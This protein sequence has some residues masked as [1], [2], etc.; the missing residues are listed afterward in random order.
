MS[1]RTK[2][3]NNQQ[4]FACLMVIAGFHDFSSSKIDKHTVPD[5]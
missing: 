1:I 4:F 5:G 3:G 2:T